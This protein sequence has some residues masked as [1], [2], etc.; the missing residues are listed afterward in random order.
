[1][2]LC[3]CGCGGEVALETNTYINGHQVLGKSSPLKGRKQP[4]ISLALTGRKRADLSAALTGKK[5]TVEHRKNQSLAQLGKKQPN[6]SKG[7]KNNPKLI[8]AAKKQWQDPI[9]RKNQSLIQKKLWADPLY[10]KNTLKAIGKGLAIHPNKPE[11]VLLNLLQTLYANEWEYSCSIENKLPDFVNEKR[12]LI[13][14]MNGCYIHSCPIHYPN[15]GRQQDNS[16]ERIEHFKNHG[17]NCLII[18]EHELTNLKEVAE[19]II[20]FINPTNERNKF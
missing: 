1:M 18:W 10:K 3:A 8:L 12:K 5:H 9:F 20:D 2:K 13:I 7:N 14:E 6:I 16:L 15:S 17:Y 19:R 11:T 4:K